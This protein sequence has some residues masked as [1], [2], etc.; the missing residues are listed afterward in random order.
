MSAGG[1]SAR[2]PGTGQTKGIAVPPRPAAA[3]IGHARGR[4]ST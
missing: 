2:S 3:H 1:T 4:K